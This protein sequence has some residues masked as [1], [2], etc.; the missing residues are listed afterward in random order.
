M[1]KGDVVVA[2]GTR[3]GLWLLRSADRQS[4]SV[5]GPHLLMKSVAACAIDTRGG[6][7]RVLAGASYD[8]WGPAVSWSDDLGETWHEAPDGSG[9]RF[10]SDLG[11]S[12]ETVWQIRPDTVDRPGVVWAGTEPT[13]LWRSEDGGETFSL[14]EGLWN[15]P[16]RPTWEPGGGGQALHTILP[17]PT[18]DS[19]IMVAMSTGGVYVSDDGG[20]TWN[21]SNG[22]I[23]ADFLPGEPPEYG[24]CV[25]KIARDA[26]EPERLFLQ[27]HPGV[28]RSDDGGASWVPI[29]DGLPS[30]FGFPVV[31]HP[32]RADTAWVVPLVADMERLP[33]E[34]TLQVWRTDDAGGTW[35]KSAVSMPGMFYASVLRDAFCSDDVPPDDGLAGLYLGTR[36]GSVFASADEGAT[37]S[38]VLSHLP[39]VLCVRAAVLPN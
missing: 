1:A 37:W 2:V 20:D 7:T 25:H 16:H 5:H 9:V 12:V 22:G 24:Q 27:N 29:A 17:H 23:T 39:D 28:Y 11:A 8:H 13:A 18:D 6:H 14:C 32:H 10:P 30:N 31:A 34:R 15:H 38:E 36:D 19:R 35:K 21:P 33:P 3:K 26:E 4:W